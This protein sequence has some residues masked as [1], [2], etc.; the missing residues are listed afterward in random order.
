MS[1]VFS[2][3]VK[4]LSELAEQTTAEDTDVMPIGAT[5]PKKIT[6]ANLKEVLGIN[7]LNRKLTLT[8]NLKGIEA[9]YDGDSAFFLD[10]K[11]SNGHTARLIVRN[12]GISFAYHNGTVW[13][14]IWS[15]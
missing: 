8:E 7:A 10:W 5:S 2:G 12:T 1:T 11:I 15:K 9:G 6:I 3:I 13:T 4:L 14:T